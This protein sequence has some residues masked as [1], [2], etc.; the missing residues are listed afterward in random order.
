MALLKILVPLLIGLAAYYFYPEDTFSPE[1]VRG[2]RVLVTGSSAGIGEQMAYEFARMGAHVMLT[3]RG[4]EQLQKV[5]KKCRD[6][7]ASSAHYVVADMGNMTAAQKVI[8]ETAAKLGGLDQLVLNHVGGSSFGKFE[9]AIEPV[10]K[11]MT[12]NFFSYAQLAISAMDLLLESKGNIVVV[13]SLAGRVPSPF[14]VSYSAAKFAVEGFFTSLRTELRLRKMDLPITVAV[15]GYIDTEMAVK[16]MENK[17]TQR[18]S[19]KEEC[20]RQIVRGGVLRYR[21]VFYPYWALKPILL[22]RELLPDLMDQVIGYG[23]RLE[24][25]L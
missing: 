2:K 4:E 15:L 24:N 8:E 12:V 10:I 21:E 22:Y 14:S 25:I 20:A 1:M 11:S 23:Y 7:G 16:Y 3:A 9:G 18:P 17:I 6:L 13:S 5:A 19:P